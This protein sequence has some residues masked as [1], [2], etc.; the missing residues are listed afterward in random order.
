MNLLYC[1]LNKT[2]PKDEAR[3]SKEQGKNAE[4]NT[5]QNTQVHTQADYQAFWQYPD[6]TI[7]EINDEIW[8]HYES[9]GTLMGPAGLV[10]YEDIGAVLRNE[11][12]SSGGSF[13]DVPKGCTDLPVLSIRCA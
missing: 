4:K 9:D 13:D 12:G 11:Y 5:Y 10:G 1:S 6:G 3:N 8:N 7:L 2:L